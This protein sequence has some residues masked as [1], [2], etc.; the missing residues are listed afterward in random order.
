MSMQ[1]KTGIKRIGSLLFAILLICGCSAGV[2]GEPTAQNEAAAQAPVSEPTEDTVLLGSSEMIES[3]YAQIITPAPETPT[4]E[5][6]AEPTPEP[7]ATPAPTDTPEPNP[8]LGTWT[9]EELPFLLDVRSDGTYLVSTNGVEKTGS[10]TYDSANLYLSVSDDETVDF[11]YYFKTGKMMHDEYVLSRSEIAEQ[12]MFSDIPTTFTSETDEVS[13][14]VRGAVVDVTLKN[15]RLAAEYCFTNRGLTPP[16]NSRD[17]FNVLDSGE[18]SAH[19]RVYKY[20]GSFTLW[21]RDTEGTVLEPIDVDVVSGF[22]YP[23]Q[24]KNLE[25]VRHSVKLVLQ[26]NNSSIESLNEMISADIAA[27]GIYTR[28]GVVTSGV[29]LISHMSEYG[30][31]IVYQ[32]KG[33]YQGMNDWGVNP[34]WGSKLDEPTSD[35]NGTYYYCGM[36]CVASIVWAYKQ[37]GMNLFTTLRSEIGR[38]GE[39]VKNNDNKIQYDRAKYGDIVRSGGHYLMI[40]DRLDQNNDGVADA[41]ITYEMWAPHLTMLVL[42][43]RQVRGRTFYSMDAFFDGT[44]KNKSKAVYWEDTFEI[45]MKELPE[46]LQRAVENEDAYQTFTAF[47]EQFGL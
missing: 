29:S 46:Y 36:Q 11:R 39:R 32:G 28:E 42:T 19:F 22:H 26:E 15:E 25:P 34:K 17:W 27:A 4:P 38:N 1:I 14:F 16:E 45:P 13:V 44:G 5:P 41:Y 35:P 9:I 12:R 37:A 20:D 8:F 3:D 2:N 7:T 33:S 6:T 40:I 43:F 23:V 21:I 24:A 18:P 47:L 10:Y 30:Y 31:S